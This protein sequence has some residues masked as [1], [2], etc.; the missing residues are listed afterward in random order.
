MVDTIWKQ[1]DKEVKEDLSRVRDACILEFLALQ[2]SGKGVGAEGI[3]RWGTGMRRQENYELC[4]SE[5]ENEINNPAF[6]LL[7]LFLQNAL[8]S[9]GM[10][11][12]SALEHS[13]ESSLSR[14]YRNCKYLAWEKIERSYIYPYFFLHFKKWH[15]FCKKPHSDI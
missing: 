3:W 15:N 11:K 13:T 2:M 7:K 5:N 12:T 10:F 9:K 1:T 6:S 4:R 14:E 8:T